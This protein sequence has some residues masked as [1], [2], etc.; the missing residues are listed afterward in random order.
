[1]EQTASK[2]KLDEKF[3]EAW[4]GLE[5]A[6]K[7]ADGPSVMTV[8]DNLK[9]RSREADAD[10][11]RA[12]RQ[13]RNYLTHSERGFLPVSDE[14]IKFL[15]DMAKEVRAARGTAKTEMISAAKYGAVS[16][17]DP[18]SKACALMLSKTRDGV[19]VLNADKKLVGVLG[20]RGMARALADAS[21]DARALL[22]GYL[23]KN[24]GLDAD[25]TET[26]AD[27]PVI[28]APKVRAAVLDAK[29]RCI[30]VLNPERPWR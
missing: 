10:R 21:Q 23:A 30:G 17:D 11:L 16:P 2:K 5:A 24:G 9:A 4:R 29:G 22:V 3:L 8:E 27:T 6:L 25:I 26:N 12:C 14:M 18:V 13:V 19:L 15:Q 28:D 1:M 7:D 20:W